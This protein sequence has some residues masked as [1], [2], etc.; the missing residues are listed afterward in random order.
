M[1]RRRQT[2]KNSWAGQFAKQASNR[3]FLNEIESYDYDLQREIQDSADR[4]ARLQYD[5]EHTRADIKALEEDPD[6][7]FYEK[8]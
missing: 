7:Y 2:V 6:G 1:A 8:E 4:N 3:R 5:I